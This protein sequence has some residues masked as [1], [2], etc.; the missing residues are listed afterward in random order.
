MFYDLKDEYAKKYQL[1]PLPQAENLLLGIDSTVQEMTKLLESGETKIHDL[2]RSLVYSKSCDIALS[3][4]QMFGSYQALSSSDVTPEDIQFSVLT[5]PCDCPINYPCCENISNGDINYI[6][7][8]PHDAELLKKQNITT[9]YDLGEKLD[10]PDSIPKLQES[11]LSM[12]GRR[13]PTSD[14]K[15]IDLYSQKSEIWKKCSKDIAMPLANFYRANRH[16]TI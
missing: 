10:H 2:V 5:M 3:R 6:V 8:F 16:H 14:N 15:I 12:V 4:R 13:D 9:I 11:I 1:Y 7:A